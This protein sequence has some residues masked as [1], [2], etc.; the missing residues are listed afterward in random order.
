MQMQMCDPWLT[1]MFCLIDDLS[2][3]PILSQSIVVDDRMYTEIVRHAPCQSEIAAPEFAAVLHSFSRHAQLH[4]GACHLFAMTLGLRDYAFVTHKTT[5]A[6]LEV[7]F[8][9]PFCTLSPRLILWSDRLL[10]WAPNT[11]N[12]TLRWR[13]RFLRLFGWRYG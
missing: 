1:A 4:R 13:L 10:H 12:A 5:T 2:R 11:A 7:R 8:Y 6:T 9:K 3:R